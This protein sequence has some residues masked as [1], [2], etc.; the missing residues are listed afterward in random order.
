MG[1]DAKGPVVFLRKDG[2]NE[3]DADH[4]DNFT[5]R[6]SRIRVPYRP[7]TQTKALKC[8]TLLWGFVVKLFSS[9]PDRLVNERVALFQVDEEIGATGEQDTVR[10]RV[11]KMEGFVEGPGT[12]VMEVGNVDGDSHL[13]GTS[14]MF[15][16][17]YRGGWGACGPRTR[18]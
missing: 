2:Q 9:A 3:P 10:F 15:F 17:G 16:A 1:S 12:V 11:E 18:G 4:C 7:L 13:Q 8:V 14:Q 6:R 5:Y